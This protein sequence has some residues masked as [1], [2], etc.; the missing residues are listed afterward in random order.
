MNVNII[1]IEPTPNP[2]SM[3]LTLSESLP[4]GVKL[5]Y[6]TEQIS[7]APE[8]VRQFLSIPGVKSLYHASNFFALERH[9][10]QDWEPILKEVRRLFPSGSQTQSQGQAGSTDTS[11]QPVNRLH[12]Y[13]QFFRKIPM[14]VKILTGTEDLRFALPE[15]FGKAAKLAASYTQ[16][17]L[18][19]RRWEEQG[20]HSG[21][22]QQI[23]GRYVQE[24][25]R[26]YSEER[27][28]RL[29]EEAIRL[30]APQSAE[31]KIASPDELKLAL[32]SDDWKT[33]YA[34]LERLEPAIDKMPLLERAIKDP[35]ASIRRLAVVYLGSLGE[36]SLP[37]LLEALEDSSPAVRRAAGDCL[38]D[39]GNPIGIPNMI[40]ALQDPSKLVR[41]RA[42]RYLF[43]VGDASALPAL[44]EALDDAEYEIRMQA[45]LAIERISG[46]QNP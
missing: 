35:K 27:L 23:G 45:Q 9:P 28:Q 17:F 19:E 26:D 37:Y 5:T 15:R 8:A 39:L 42:A 7:E 31:R 16:S 40:K 18:T 20:F 21:D 14:Q 24:I 32:Q 46:E 44:S 38:S 10:K 6:T 43:E 12:V 34:A 2:N 30:D 3:K 1:A 4:S 13:I 22:P 25:T 11:D 36:S 41:W 33:R 29:V